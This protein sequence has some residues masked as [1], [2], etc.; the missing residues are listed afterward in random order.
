[1]LEERSSVRKTTQA[2]TRAARKANKRRQLSPHEPTLVHRPVEVCGSLWSAHR[3]IRQARQCTCP[4]I[5]RR[6]GL[7]RQK[8]VVTAVTSFNNVHWCDIIKS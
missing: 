4:K 2:M 8:A 5:D 1:M 6:Q 7:S 3:A